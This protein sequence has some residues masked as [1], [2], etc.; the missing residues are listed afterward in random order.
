MM[1]LQITKLITISWVLDTVFINIA[2]PEKN[3]MFDNNMVKSSLQEVEASSVKTKLLVST[4]SSSFLPKSP[5]IISTCLSVGKIIKMSRARLNS[6]RI[7]S[8]H[9][10]PR[11]KNRHGK[12]LPYFIWALKDS[13]EF[14]WLLILKLSMCQVWIGKSQ[15]SDVQIWISFYFYTFD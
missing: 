15:N 1:H 11:G 12:H 10:E 7:K 9:V 13:T 4:A 2:S 14:K 6:G 5:P 3:N 8:A